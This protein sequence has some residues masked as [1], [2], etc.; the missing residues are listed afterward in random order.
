MKS[1]RVAVAVA[2]LGVAVTACSSPVQAGSAAVVGNERISASDLSTNVKQLESALAKA[3][4]P[5][6]QLG[7]PVTQYALLQ[8]VNVAQFRQ[9]ATK[10][11]TKVTDGEIDQLI[12]SQGGLAAL[13][14]QTLAQGV[15]P[16]YTRE[17]LGTSIAINKMMQQY[18][19]GTDEA[20][21]QRGQQKLIE[22][23]SAI[24]VTYSPRYGTFD[25]QKGFVDAGRFGKPASSTQG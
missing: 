2:A 14:K 6:S 10:A 22:E 21:R 8:M 20:A 19:G 9:L 23:A 25:P 5:Q 17:W 4:I 11:G 24:K 15:P 18:G 3:Q 13:E 7:L 12:A 1:I 16:A